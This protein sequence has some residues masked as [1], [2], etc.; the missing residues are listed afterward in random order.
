MTCVSGRNKCLSDLLLPLPISVAFISYDKIGES[1]L[2]G[3]FN[4]I[5]WI[6]VFLS[7]HS[8]SFGLLNWKC[9]GKTKNTDG[10][11]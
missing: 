9:K 4:D 6:L 8:C 1:G 3:P 10:E 11:K 2:F 7:P 5:L